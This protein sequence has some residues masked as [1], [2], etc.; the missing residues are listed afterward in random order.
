LAFQA[1]MEEDAQFSAAIRQGAILGAE[2]GH[3]HT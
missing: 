1:D 3:S 2:S